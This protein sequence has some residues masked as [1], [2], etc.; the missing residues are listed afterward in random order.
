MFVV[1]L[2]IS[3]F[4]FFLIRLLYIQ[5]VKEDF[6]SNIAKKQHGILVKLEPQ[7][8]NIYDKLKRVLAIYLDTVSIYAVPKEISDKEQAA[9]ILSKEFGIEQKTIEKRLAKDNYFAWVKRKTGPEDAEKVKNL[10]LKGVY[11]TNEQKRFYPGGRLACHIIGFTGIDNDGLEGVELYYNKELT[12][13]PGWRR[14]SKDAKQR[15][16]A[17][18]EEAVLPARDGNS[19]LLTIDEVIQ[20]ILE[21]EVDRIVNSSHPEAVSI[22]AMEPYGG[23]ILGMANYPVY[24]P[25]DPG[26]ASEKGYLKNR[27]ISDAFEPGSIFKVIT[28]TALLN[29]NAVDF[30]TEIYCENG[31]YKVGKRILHDYHSYGKLT[32]REVIEKSSNIGTVKAAEKIGKDTLFAYIKKFN[33]SSQTGI[34]LP[35]EASG[36]LR[37]VSGWSYSDMT[38]IPMGQGIAITGI[39]MATA[40]SAIANGGL[41]MR[42]YV[43]DEFLNEKGDVIQKNKPKII[44]RVMSE[45]TS[46]KVKELMEGVVERGTGKAAR[47]QNFRAGGKTG[48]AQKINPKGGYYKNKYIASFVGFAPYEKPEVVLIVS[49]DDPRG[50]HFGGQIGAPAFKN[51]MEKVLS[52]MEIESDKHEIKK[53]S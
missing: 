12:G 7:R 48:T 10:K 36:I 21:M 53:N 30:D 1:T 51:I 22:I 42:P 44:R 38:T 24:N 5:I 13:E 23:T 52:Y 29:E 41:L 46:A 6:L 27:A 34:D 50:K 4:F 43:V 47:M 8:G 14:S 25:N 9:K 19:V 26:E 39:Q 28:A 20:H 16:I 15:E 11:V 31:S 45:E 3:L 40:V 32:F 49:I 2:F 35:G 17:S 33:F 18:L 37:D